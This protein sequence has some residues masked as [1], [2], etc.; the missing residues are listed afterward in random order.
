MKI[1]AGNK[2]Q[3]SVL[4]AILVTSVVLFVGGCTVVKT[5]KWIK[6]VDGIADRRFNNTNDLSLIEPNSLSLGTGTKSSGERQVYI[7]TTSVSMEWHDEYDYWP[8]EGGGSVKSVQ[9]TNQ[10]PS[11]HKES[12]PLALV[13][14]LRE[15]GNIHLSMKETSDWRETSWSDLGMP[16]DE[17]GIPDTSKWQAPPSVENSVVVTVESTTNLI[18]W[19]FQT[20]VS[21][22]TNQPTYLRDDLE[23]KKF[24]RAYRW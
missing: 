11:L 20:T 14:L 24:Y 18:N 4:L 13:I 17:Y 2:K 3:G 21:V 6:R 19:S 22:M 7:M 12:S 10:P 23:P 1:D 16:L 9:S 15:D 5:I 8:P